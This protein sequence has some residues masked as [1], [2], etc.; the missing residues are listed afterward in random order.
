M[1]D[2]GG[3]RV[4]QNIRM[5]GIY[6]KEWIKKNASTE[7]PGIDQV[8]GKWS[9]KSQWSSWPAAGFTIFEN[10]CWGYFTEEESKLKNGCAIIF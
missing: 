8:M 7:L 5:S 3:C 4:L 6:G 2:F 9:W 1:L 10:K